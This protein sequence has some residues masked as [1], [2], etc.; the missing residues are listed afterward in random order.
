MH[1]PCTQAYGRDAQRSL[2]CSVPEIKLKRKQTLGETMIGRIAGAAALTA[3][4]TLAAAAADAGAFGTAEEARAMLERAVAAL[5]ADKA[6][7][8]EDFNT[9]ASGFKDRDLY[10]ACAD[11]AG[12]V[13]AHPNKELIGQDRNSMKD[14][15]GK[16]FGAEVQSVA[17]EGKIAEVTYMYPRPGD[18]KTPVAKV[19]FVTKAADQVCLVGYYK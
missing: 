4:F 16:A 17:Q 8:L 15:D 18:D 9:G 2:Q 3:M 6:K 1:L 19:A 5:T 7:A 10:V 13:T 11:S 14:V 12:K